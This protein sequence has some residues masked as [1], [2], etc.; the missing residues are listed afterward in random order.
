MAE[1]LKEKLLDREKLADLVAGPDAYR[2]LPRLISVVQNAPDGVGG[3]GGS[4]NVQLSLE[5]TYA[6]I[7]P[8]R[9]AGA[10]SAFLSIMRGCNNMCAF[11]IVPFTRGR[12]RSRPVDSIL[13]E[14]EQLSQ[15][16]VKEVTLLGQNVNSYAYLPPNDLRPAS[17]GASPAHNDPFAVY[18]P[19][20]KS[21]YKPRRQ[22]A[23][24]FAE[25]L[26]LVAQ[27]D[28]E[29]RVRFTSPHPK[30]FS[31]K[32]LQ[33]IS[34]YPNICKQLHMPA[35]SGST[36]MLELMRRGYSRE[37]Y[38]SLVHRVRQVLP[39]VALS[40][41]IIVGFCGEEEEDH[42]L[43]VDLMRSIRYDNAFMFM[44]SERDKTFAAR[45]LKDDVA[46]EVKARRLQE[47][48]NTYKSVLNERNKGEVG[49]V[50]LVLVEGPARKEPEKWMGK[51]CT[52]K[53]V[54][55]DDLRVSDGLKDGGDP[56]EVAASTSLPALRAFERA[57]VKIGPGDYVAVRIV[58]VCGGTLVAQPL[59]KTTIREFSG[60]FGSRL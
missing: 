3:E 14:V 57:Q 49:K 56:S 45:H 42:Q 36:R 31:D 8:L 28:P 4:M 18:A 30:D 1:R 7:T 19:G 39:S 53:K 10:V 58:D 11:C 2:D 60:V 41:D 55:F 6:D 17:P 44:Y 27:V 40:T 29:M 38:D 5:E 21:I 16:G 34:D 15:Q 23:T 13:K 26:A 46:S 50:H 43:T 37:A 32:V 24:T 59:A 47:V 51:T 48:M 20:F 22:G 33:A 9:P 54:K 35:Q 52:M 25:L 12:E